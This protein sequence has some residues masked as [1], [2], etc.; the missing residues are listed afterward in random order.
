MKICMLTTSYP[1]FSGDYVGSFVHDLAKEL[2]KNNIEVNIVAPHDKD[3]KNHEV[4]DGVNIFRFSYWP[5]KKM[6][7]I[8]YGGGIPY[9][10]VHTIWAKI[11]LPFFV[12]FFFLMSLRISKK[13]DIIH[14]QFLLSGFVGVFV[15]RITGRRLV[16]TAH[17]TDIYAIPQR[18][19]FNKMYIKTIAHSDNLITVSNANK[20]RLTKIGLREDLITVIPNG[21]DISTI[22]DI[23]TLKQERDKLEITW[24][25]RMV[26]VK[27][28]QYLIKAMDNIVS[29]Y[30]NAH[31]TLIGDGPLK[32][33][34]KRVVKELSID[35]NISFIGFINNEDVMQ[36]LESSDIFVLPSISEGFPVVILEAMA[37]AKPVVASNVG[38]IPDAVEDGNTGFLVEPKNPEQ[39]TEKIS[40]LIDHP[41]E[42]K[43][44]GNNGR[45]MVEE[46]FTWDKITGKIIG[47]YKNILGRAKD[48]FMLDNL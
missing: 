42:R 27:G 15:K 32:K 38:G 40:Y 19:G 4:M 45:R 2:V 29:G 11:Q 8:A 28:L 39:L 30:P 10:L 3:T 36:Y 35:S 37:V 43:R 47:I 18:G 1:R 13:C 7:K 23:S 48:E 26:E 6:N 44:M 17:G 34:F 24:V 25:G 31:L 22:K 21:R 16:I 46:K 33:K 14:A 12:I 9:N 5:V 20:K 41:E